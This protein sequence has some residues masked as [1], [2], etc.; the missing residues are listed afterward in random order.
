MM[1]NPENTCSELGGTVFPRLSLLLQIQCPWDVQ[2]SGPVNSIFNDGH[3]GVI[4]CDVCS[5]KPYRRVVVLSSMESGFC[6]PP[7]LFVVRDAIQ[8]RKTKTH[9]RVESK[10]SASANRGKSGKRL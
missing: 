9:S 3:L 8:P 1:T 10:V 5:S 2:V 7:A 4:L 6:H